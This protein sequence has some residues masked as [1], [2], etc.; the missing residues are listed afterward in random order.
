[1]HDMKMFELKHFLWSGLFFLFFLTCGWKYHLSYQRYPV[2]KTKGRLLSSAGLLCTWRQDADPM[3]LSLPL[4]VLALWALFD[5]HIVSITLCTAR[6]AFVLCL[7]VHSRYGQQT[8]PSIFMWNLS[9]CFEI[10]RKRKIQTLTS[11]PP[12]IS[13]SCW[14]VGSWPGWLCVSFFPCTVKPVHAVVIGKGRSTLD[15]Q[16]DLLC[17]WY[18]WE[19]VPHSVSAQIGN[20]L[21]H[22]TI[23]I[24]L[25]KQQK[26][27][28]KPQA[29]TKQGYINKCKKFDQKKCFFPSIQW[30]DT[31]V[32]LTTQCLMNLKLHPHHH[33]SWVI[34]PLHPVLKKYRQQVTKFLMQ[35]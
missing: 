8:I 7:C 34:C 11:S 22:T 13:S 31:G 12:V 2:T 20:R 26:G 32:N 3:L 30:M 4:S 17:Q 33:D 29:F 35:V 10:N 9:Y 19:T 27:S 1:M 25:G 5:L 18:Q 24:S 21:W 16:S 14:I 15:P 28:D 6:C 23:T